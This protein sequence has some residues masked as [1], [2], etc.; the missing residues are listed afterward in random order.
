MI[1]MR[2]GISSVLWQLAVSLYL[3]ANGII[4]LQGGTF[5][6]RGIFHDIFQRMGFSGDILGVL[7]IAFSVIAIVAA[8]TILFGLLAVKIP[9][10]SMIVLVVAITWTVYIVIALISWVNDGFVNLFPELS[11]FAVNL[12]VLSS[13]LAASKRFM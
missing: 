7:V 9:F 3:F 13:L 12:M 8:V 2:Y 10:L 11:M 4:G 1:P 5:F 6:N